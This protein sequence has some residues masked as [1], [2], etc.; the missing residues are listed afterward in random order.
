MERGIT[1]VIGVL[2]TRLAIYESRSLKDKRRVVKS[3]KDRIRHKFNVS[4]AE[5]DALDARQSAVITAA[6]VSNDGQFAEKS[7][8]QVLNHIAA[9]RGASVVD[10]DIEML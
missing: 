3:I 4:I 2:T 1:M 5:T 7:M 8:Q 6:I 9:H 10:Y